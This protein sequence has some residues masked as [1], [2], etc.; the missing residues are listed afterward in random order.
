MLGKFGIRSRMG[1]H[2]AAEH[3]T[4]IRFDHNQ[5]LAVCKVTKINYNE[6]TAK[7]NDERV[8]FAD[9]SDSQAVLLPGI[10]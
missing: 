5:D 6:K 3:E 2:N 1:L 8:G 4:S 9:I 7:K 10:K